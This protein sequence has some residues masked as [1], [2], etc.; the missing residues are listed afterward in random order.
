MAIVKA[1]TGFNMNN[2]NA[3][4]D[5]SGIPSSMTPTGFTFYNPAT[6]VTATITGSDM[7]YD[8]TGWS[9]GTATGASF[10]KGGV[11]LLSISNMSANG[12]VSYYDTG[13]GGE[14]PGLSADI[15]YWL[16]GDDV[17]GGMSGNETLKGYAGNDTFTG[18][19][20]D[21]YIDGGDG[22]DTVRYEA[23]RADFVV[24]KLANGYSVSSSQYS[25][26]R[27]VNVEV[28]KF[29][30]ATL[31][32]DQAVT[33]SSGTTSSTATYL[34]TKFG[35]SMDDAR[36]WVMNHLSTPHDIY[37]ICHNNAITSAM[38]ADIVQP[39]FTGITIT[40]AIVNE[41]LQAQGLSTL[42]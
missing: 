12:A 18:D 5:D 36:G 15:A 31:N 32:I 26:D 10:S 40:G 28:L 38:L 30:D 41:W 16:R 25:T 29:L 17:I 42:A 4:D 7:T 9:G 8:Q 34:Q 1:G 19:V 39:S 3:L 35:V 37:D 27:L 24:T 11:L 2:M 20:G 33:S 13:Y 21:D 14:G 22:T 23:N 6:G